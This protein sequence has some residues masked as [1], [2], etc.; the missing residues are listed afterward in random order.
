M[1]KGTLITG[2]AYETTPNQPILAGEKT[3]PAAF[4]AAERAQL[5]VPSQQPARLGVLARGADV[6]VLWRRDEDSV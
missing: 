6:L 5:L 1:S 2:Y 4:G 3:V